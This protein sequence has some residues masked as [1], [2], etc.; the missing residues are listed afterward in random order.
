[1]TR[2]TFT[3]VAV[4]CL[5][6]GACVPAPNGQLQPAPISGNIVQDVNSILTQQIR[7]QVV[8]DAKDAESNLTQAMTVGALP[9]N[10]P[11]LGCVQQA[12]ALLGVDNPAPSFTPAISGLESFASAAYIRAQQVKSISGSLQLPPGCEAIIG[13]MNLDAIAQALKGLPDGSLIPTVR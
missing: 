13:R 7:T 5:G 1:V 6:L 10:D 2:T 3:A 4:L 9:A 12:N 11:A 8:Q